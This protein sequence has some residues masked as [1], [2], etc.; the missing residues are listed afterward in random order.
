MR[1]DPALLIAV[2]IYSCDGTLLFWTT[3]RDFESATWME[4]GPGPVDLSVRVP[5]DV[6]NEGE[7]YAQLC[8]MLHNR[9][10]LIPEGVGPQ[11][12]FAVPPRAAPTEFWDQR[13]NGYL[14]PVLPWK[15]KQPNASAPG[16][17]DETAF[18]EV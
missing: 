15:W 2:G 5:I 3:H 8:L 9:T 1:N 6:L 7:Y 14:C 12:H 13:R 18:Q 17:S 16:T 10:Y 11:A 4:I